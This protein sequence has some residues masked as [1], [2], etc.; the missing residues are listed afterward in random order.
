MSRTSYPPVKQG[1]IVPVVYQRSFA[2]KDRAR[3]AVARG[4]I[5]ALAAVASDSWARSC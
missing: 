5:E 1:H 2:V 4:G 3:A